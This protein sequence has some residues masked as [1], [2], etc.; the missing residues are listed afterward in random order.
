MKTTTKVLLATAMTCALSAPAFADEAVSGNNYARLSAGVISPEDIDVTVGPTVTFSFDTGYTVSG[1]VGT[2]VNDNITVEGE[3][4]YLSADFD[5][6]ESGGVSVAIDGDFSSALL[7][8]NAAFH[9]SGKNAS[10]DPYVGA[11]VGV[12][13]SKLSIDSIGGVAVNQSDSAT[14]AAAQLS[15]GLNLSLASGVS[16]GAQYRYLYIDSGSDDSDG[17]SGHNLTANVTFAF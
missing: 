12:A 11:G 1:A 5:K 15:A 2:W 3:A 16:V 10:L 7:L 4:T 17:F 6:G 9:L 13:F 14:D 8:A